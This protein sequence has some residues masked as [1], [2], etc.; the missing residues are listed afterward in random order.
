MPKKNLA[1]SNPANESVAPHPIKHTAR[2]R[3]QPY[4]SICTKDK[5]T[6]KDKPAQNKYWP[7]PIDLGERRQSHRGNT[8][9]EG[10]KGDSEIIYN[11]ADVPLGHK[12]F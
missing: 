9:P 4:S 1:T 3:G 2:R 8:E 10:E 7:S 6:S 12:F 11:M 5:L